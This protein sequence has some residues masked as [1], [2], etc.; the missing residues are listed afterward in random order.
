MQRYNPPDISPKKSPLYSKGNRHK[1]KEIGTDEK[2]TL[3]PFPSD[4]YSKGIHISKN[5]IS[6]WETQYRT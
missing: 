6:I 2:N 5:T 3:Q 4:T 1:K